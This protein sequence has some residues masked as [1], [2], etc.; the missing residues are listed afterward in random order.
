MYCSTDAKDEGA[1][2][3]FRTLS[4]DGKETV[5]NNLQETQI[6]VKPPVNKETSLSGNADLAL[7][8]AK[9]GDEPTYAASL[10]F[11]EKTDF[12]QTGLGLHGSSP[13]V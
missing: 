1:G 11:Q 12:L 8:S 5:N 3:I 7:R 2:S 13:S 10:G 6:V 4:V 9:E